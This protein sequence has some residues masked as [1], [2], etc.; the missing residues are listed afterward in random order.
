MPHA[1]V[2]TLADLLELDVEEIVAGYRS[3]ERGDP[4][5]GGNSSRAFH[6]GWRARM[7]DLG[8]IAVPNAHRRLVRD[9]LAHHREQSRNK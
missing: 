7:M 4:E 2:E 3:A 9:Y 1:P 6:H 8:E 5:P